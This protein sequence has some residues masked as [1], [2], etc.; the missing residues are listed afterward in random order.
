MNPVER[1]TAVTDLLLSALVIAGIVWLARNTMPSGARRLWFGGLFAFA[2]AG[3]LG[4]VVHWFPLPPATRTLLW[5]PLYLTLGTALALM[6]AGGIADWRGY[7]AGRKALPFFLLLALAFYLATRA[8]GGKFIV[9]VAFQALA[10]LV[11]LAVYG[12]L[13]MAERIR[14]SGW[15]FAGFVL[16]LLAGMAQAMKS[17]ELHLVWTFD[18]NGIY[19]LVQMAGVICLCAGLRW[20]LGT[21]PDPA[22]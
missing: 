7:P 3:V 17:I 14:G 20:L 8:S 9:F 4:F 21:A 13:W 6:M 11:L 15:M 12:R 1:V 10:I 2:A 19:H 22:R 16:S 18:H 5:Q